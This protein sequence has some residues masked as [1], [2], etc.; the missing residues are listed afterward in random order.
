MKTI[1]IIISILILIVSLIP[2]GFIYY[3]L[4]MVKEPVGAIIAIPIGLSFIALLALSLNT[5]V[6]L[7]LK[8]YDWFDSN[9]K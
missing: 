1:N 2:I 3:A 8:F 6:I 4:D 9:I 5:G 7:M